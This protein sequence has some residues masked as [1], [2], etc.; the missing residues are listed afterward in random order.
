MLSRARFLPL[1]PFNWVPLREGTSARANDA[2]VRQAL[3][4]FHSI[5]FPCE[6]GR[7]SVYTP[8][9]LP[10]P[11]SIQLGSPARGDVSLQ[12]AEQVLIDN[13]V[14]IQLG[15]PAR[16]DA[17]AANPEMLTL[18]WGFHSIGF[19]CERGPALPVGLKPSPFNWFP[20]NWVPLREGTLE[21]LVERR[22]F[23]FPVFPF[24]WVPLREGT[25]TLSLSLNKT[26]ISFHSIGFPCERGLG[27]N[28]LLQ[29]CICGIPVSI[30]LGSP[31]RGDLKDSY[32]FAPVSERFPFNWV[33]LREGT[34]FT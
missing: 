26:A 8:E 15:S 5:G 31:A 11:V 4:G 7:Q 20:F 18:V 27:L 16:G 22:E 19:P 9:F 13:L 23:R 25:T 6:R 28:L 3:I 24:N 32:H 14:S 29:G 1:F 34:F 2:N 33:P 30:Q 10:G 21:C 17:A 12:Q